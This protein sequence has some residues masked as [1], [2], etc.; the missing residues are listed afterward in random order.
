MERTNRKVGMQKGLG[1]G[2]Q[3]VLLTQPEPVALAK[4]IAHPCRERAAPAAAV[5]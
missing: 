5:P 3:R 2:L 4:V 1:L